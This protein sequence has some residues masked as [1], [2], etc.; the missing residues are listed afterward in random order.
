MNKNRCKILSIYC[1]NLEDTRGTPIRIR[2]LLG[3]L[4]KNS[5]F[6]LITGSWDAGLKGAKHISLCKQY[7][8]NI[9][10]LYKYIKEENIDVVIGHTM[11]AY[12][13]LWPLRF[14]T[15]A[16]IVL[17]MHGFLEEEGYFHGDISVWRYFRNKLVYTLF[18]RHCHLITTCSKTATDILKKYNDNVVT[19]FGGVDLSLFNPAVK[20]GGYVRRGRVTFGY[21]GNARVWQ[22][23]DLLVEAFKEHVKLYPDDRLVVL[24]SE[25]GVST[26]HQNIQIVSAL[27]HNK[28][29]SLIIDCDILVIPRPD[30][31]VNKISFPSKLMEYMAMGKTII[32]SRTSD[33]DQVLV[34]GV[35]GLLYQ[36]GDLKGMLNCMSMA[37]DAELRDQLGRAAF[38]LARDNFTW[39][40]QGDIMAKHIKRILK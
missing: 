14:L 22:G 26:Q 18:Y 32:A 40:H 2:S 28:V 35:S 7:I 12:S 9:R 21:A 24:T 33:I 1:S 11:V 30:I 16:K 15:K 4:L 10:K 31:V 5:E 23:L 25:K 20:S 19:I 36:S 13:Y 38:G 6:E 29:P 8:N 39:E 37:R 34:D 27:P 3:E 17:E